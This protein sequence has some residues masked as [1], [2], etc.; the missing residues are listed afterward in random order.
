MKAKKKREQ[1]ER[2]RQVA[3]RKKH[4]SIG[5]IVGGVVVATGLYLFIGGNRS[6]P[7][8]DDM[9]RVQNESASNTDDLIIQKKEYYDIQSRDHITQGQ[10][11]DAYTTNPPTSGPHA[12]AVLGGF[13]E[14]GLAD[15]QAVHNLEHGYIW[16]SY[17][18]IP[19]DQVQA[20]KELT[21]KYPGRVIASERMANDFDGIALVAWGRSMKIKRF[22]AD[23]I[24]TFIAKNYNTSPERLA[25]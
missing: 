25:T 24:E 16:I 3:Q 1:K 22:D 2:A 15:E 17:K 21:Q 19:D 20:I 7:Q 10:E 23:L 11:H 18:N 14:D 5:V 8:K 12:E 9:Q 6:A 13:Y 4:I